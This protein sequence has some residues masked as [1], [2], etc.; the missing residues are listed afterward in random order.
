MIAIDDKITAEEEVILTEV[1][2]ILAGY[3]GDD[4]R[5]E[6]YSVVIVPRNTEQS[7]TLFC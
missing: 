4:G 1:L 5:V 2:A 3:G 7:L 6:I